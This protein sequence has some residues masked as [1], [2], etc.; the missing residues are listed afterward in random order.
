MM[1]QRASTGLPATLMLFIFFTQF[2]L[3]SW[4]VSAADDFDSLRAEVSAANS[5]R[6]R[7]ITLSVDIILAA[8]LP[9]IT[10]S[11]TIDGAGF[12][13]SGNDA[14]RIFDVNGGALTLSNVTLTGGKATESEGGAIRLRNGAEV[15]IERSTLSSNTATHGGAIATSSGGDRLTISD[16]DFGGN[17]AEQSAGAIYANGGI[18]NITGGSFIRN[19][20]LYAFYTLIEGVNSEQRSVDDEGCHHVRYV[21]S[22]IDAEL[23]T[24]VD[25]GAI[26][27]RNGAR[28]SVEGSSFSENSATY[29][30]AISTASKNIRLTVD[31]SSFIGNRA[32]G[33]GG[34]IAASWLGGGSVSISSS[35]F[36]KNS[37]V[38]H[39]GGAIEASHGA[40]DITNSTFSENHAG[41]DGGAIRIDDD[42]EVTITHA[43]LVDNWSGW[44]KAN[45][46][47]K[48]GATA[49]LRNSIIQSEEEGEDCVGAWEH[50]GNL[51]S[52]G[53]CA[54]RPSDDP[55]LGELTG[56]PAYYPL[57]DRSP[58][59]DYAD[60]QFCLE[61]DQ[62]GTPRPQSGGCD[63]GAIES[64]GAIAA[65]PTPV[66]PLVCSLAYEIV[67]ANRDWP[68]GGC[69][70]GSGV[71]TIVFDKD[72]ILFEPLPAIASHIIIEG[73]GFSISGNGNFRI[74]DV[75]GGILTVKNLTML[76]G[77]AANGDGGAI[78]LQN[79]GRATVSD[80]RFINNTAD[81]G[82]A[83]F[84]GWEGVDT[85][86]VTVSNS[87]F[88]EN[89]GRNG[90]GAIYAGGG[91]VS[92]SNSSFANNTASGYGYGSAIRMVNHFTRLDVVNSSFI[93]NRNGALSTENG[94]TASLTHVTIHGGR[95]SV[96]ALHTRDDAFTSAGNFN[97]RNSIIV[98]SVSAEICANLK[99]NINNLIKDGSCSPALSG[100]PMLEETTDT[101][102][103]IEL[104]PG[105]P[106]INAANVT[107]CPETDQL[108]RA[109][110]FVGRCDIGAIE[111]IP[112]SQALS[113]CTA[114]TTHLLNLRDGPSGKIIGGIP[115]NATVSVKARTPRWYEVEHEGTSGWISA[116]YVEKEGACELD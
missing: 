116:D 5:G 83:V 66:P 63:I 57:R 92:V 17:I 115:Q 65:E 12:S 31:N 22:E 40:F 64:R 20:A 38:E 82:G 58:A 91:T 26:R 100:D 90:G 53:T 50:V 104:Q 113:D 98:G 109:R 34:A 49:Y 21:R 86:W 33:S 29:G 4:P 47:S 46:I 28:V 105:S 74:F 88:V 45:A 106:A 24:N 80:S 9:A 60:P 51:S 59:V 79:G 84:I 16:S 93:K 101:A 54:D 67:A 71:D 11:L 94:V 44:H 73:N 102:A 25:G 8:P 56:S 23:Q 27:L 87:S 14:H 52:D 3:S 13:I 43:T 95:D 41:G 108:G 39:D 35:S 18:V 97:L 6:S 110:S 111:A 7:V 19:C 103:H 30:G 36:L 107:F 75:D 77:N 61:T 81:V 89:H 62:L 114:T 72:I 112:V 68:A 69:P 70:A 96:L 78:K 37:A 42:A 99:Q 10:G 32:R 2:I 76:D 85:S 1:T 15:T 48:S 55:R